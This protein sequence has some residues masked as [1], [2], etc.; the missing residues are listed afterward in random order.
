M[1]S[2]DRPEDQKYFEHLETMQLSIIMGV[3]R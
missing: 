2:E 1:D 3:R